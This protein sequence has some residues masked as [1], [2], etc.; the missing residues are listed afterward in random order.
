MLLPSLGRR[1]LLQSPVAPSRVP[2]ERRH[3]GAVGR[4]GTAAARTAAGPLPPP[5]P[6]NSGCWPGLR[7]VRA[8]EAGAG[9]R[10]S[11]AEGLSPRQLFPPAALSSWLRTGAEQPNTCAGCY[12]TWRTQSSPCE[13][14]PSG[15][16][17][18]SGGAVGDSRKSSRSSGRPFM[19]RGKA[20][21]YH[22][23]TWKIKPRFLKDL[24]T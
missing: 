4:G 14:R 9:R 24:K 2:M 3:R 10:E 7:A 18:G 1:S 22:F 5:E 17:E 15:S 8:G 6:G 21:G 23:L 16:W 12:R 19:P 13:Q 20:P 11:P